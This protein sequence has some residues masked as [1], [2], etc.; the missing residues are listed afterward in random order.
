MNMDTLIDVNVGRQRVGAPKHLIRRWLRGATILLA[1]GAVYALIN[2]FL[3]TPAP[4][5][6]QVVHQI[7]LLPPPP[8]P[9]IEQPQPEIKQEV[10]IPEPQ[11]V[12]KDDAPPPGD[13]G[14]DADGNGTDGFQLRARKGGRDLLGAGGPLAWYASRIEDSIKKVISANK[15]ARNANY[16]LMVKLWFKRDGSVERFELADSTGDPDIDQSI[17]LALARVEPLGGELPADLK[18]PVRLRIVSR[19]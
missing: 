16:I 3:S 15:K 4:R 7:S 11:P 6:K 18:Q 14:V 8:P 10:N 2:N 12:A 9:P 13:L 19:Q 1:V 5:M 17:K